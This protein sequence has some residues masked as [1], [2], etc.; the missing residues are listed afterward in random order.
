MVCVAFGAGS[1]G[2]ECARTLGGI[3]VKKTS[4]EKARMANQ[5]A[6]FSWGMSLEV[7]GGHQSLA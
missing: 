2:K 5:G 3:T 1:L 7:V 4:H 6:G